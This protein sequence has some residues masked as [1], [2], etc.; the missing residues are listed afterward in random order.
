MV[1]LGR[2]RQ[3]WSRSERGEVWDWPGAQLLACVNPF[4]S[5]HA[6]AQRLSSQKRVK[7]QPIHLGNS[8]VTSNKQ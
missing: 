8:S 4:S 5:Y 1:R 7:I 2:S 6:G 3:V